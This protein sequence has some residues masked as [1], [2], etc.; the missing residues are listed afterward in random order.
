[1]WL[2]HEPYHT[3]DKWDFL[4]APFRAWVLISGQ[5]HEMFTEGTQ[6]TYQNYKQLGPMSNLPRLKWG[7]SMNKLHILFGN[8][9][10]LAG[11]SRM[12]GG[13]GRQIMYTLGDFLFPCGLTFLASPKLSPGHVLVARL[14]ILL[15][16]LHVMICCAPCRDCNSIL[17]IQLHPLFQVHGPPSGE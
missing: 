16:W 9:P 5:K 15:I 3:P 11:K 7:K 1:M 6:E 13:F 4:T 12:H 10:W 14:A 2:H 8:Q 17:G